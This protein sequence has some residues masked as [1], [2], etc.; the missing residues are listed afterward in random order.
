MNQDVTACYICEKRFS[1]KFV[2]DKNYWKVRDHTDA[3][4][5]VYLRFNV[6]IEMAAV[7]LN[8]SSYDYHFI[9]KE[10]ASKFEGRLKC[11]GESTEKCNSKTLGKSI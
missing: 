4:H 3:Y 11:L 8:G 10:I 5:T 2:R 6:P 1:K 7:F 9:I